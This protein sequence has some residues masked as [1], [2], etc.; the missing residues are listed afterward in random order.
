MAKIDPKTRNMILAGVALL[1]VIVVASSFLMPKGDEAEYDPDDPDEL[2]DG[3]GDDYEDDEGEDEVIQ[4]TESTQETAP[5]TAEPQPIEETP[6]NKKDAVSEPA[7][8][9]PEAPAAPAEPEP[10]PVEIKVEKKKTPPNDD[11]G[12]NL[13]FLDR[14]SVDCGDKSI[15]N[16]FHLNREKDANGSYNKIQYNYTCHTGRDGKLT[17]KNSG[18]N[19]DGGGNIIYLDRHSVNCEDQFINQFRL[20]R[21]SG[22]TIRYDYK[23]SDTPI[24]EGTC[25]TDRIAPQEDGGGNL[26]YLDRQNVSCKDGEALT[27]F[28]LTR[29][30]GN[31]V[32]YEYTCCKPKQ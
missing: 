29:P 6:V 16:Q 30:S 12:G 13:I 28:R 5:A 27:K 26:I 25:R 11:G 20:T 10:E 31:T 1:F 21:P 3:E 23:C 24:D 4:E 9:V 17:Q 19:E 32:A 18:D 7:A 8:V 2:D 15:M 22:N 14:H